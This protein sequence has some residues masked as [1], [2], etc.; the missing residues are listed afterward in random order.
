MTYPNGQVTNY[1]YFSAAQDERLQTIQNLNSSSAVLSQFD[2][3]YDAKGQIASWKQQA[4]SNPAM[5]YD[6]GYDPAGQLTSD[7]LKTDSTN[8]V[9]HQYYYNYDAAANRTS[10]QI[11]SSVTKMVPNSVNQITSLS[12]GGPTRFQGTIS[13]PGNVTVNGQPANMSSSTNFVANPSLNGGTST[14]AV[15]ATDGSG[16]AT[17]N[18]YQVVIPPQSTVSPSYDAAGRMT[19]NG[20]GQAYTWDAENRLMQITQGSNTYQFAYDAL[21]RRISETDNG[22]LT[23]QWV[24]VD[25]GSSWLNPRNDRQQR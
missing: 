13:A 20:N 14:V 9:L 25:T 7:V 21:G 16:N 4:D 24:W 1:S 11:D 19:N 18:H 5:R 3:T 2:Y 23:K 8:A 12:A 17:T 15:V 10:E 22:T 6:I